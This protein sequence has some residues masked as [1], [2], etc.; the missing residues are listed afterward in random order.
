MGVGHTLHGFRLKS[1]FNQGINPFLSANFLKRLQN[2]DKSL[3]KA[4]PKAVAT[5]T[6]QK[7]ISN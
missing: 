3:Y 7:R 2:P 1:L 4:V 6:S 5:T